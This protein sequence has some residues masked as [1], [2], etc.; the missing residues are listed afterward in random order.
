MT[1]IL[2]V[3]SGKG[4][5]GKSVFTANL[6]CKLASLGKTVILIDLD[7]GGAN[8]HTFL[9]LKNRFAGLGNLIHKQEDRFEALLMKTE[10]DRLYFIPGDRLL[11]GTA[12]LNFFIKQ[13]IIRS[14]QKLIAD[15]IILDLG[16]GSSYNTIDFFL[17]SPTG[18][19]LTTPETPSI[20]NAYG[21]LK[22]VVFRLLAR[23]FPR[24][25][26]ERR[27]VH[28]F[29]TQRIE[30]SEL[31]LQTLLSRLGQVS[32]DSGDKATQ[33]LSSLYP[34]VVLNMGKTESDLR[35]GTK[36]RSIVKSNLRIEIEY[37][38][39]LQQDEA[40]TRSIITRKPSVLLEPQSKFSRSLDQTARRLLKLP[41]TPV[42]SLYEDNQDLDELSS[43]LAQTVGQG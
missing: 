8:L 41:D 29:M 34:R 37:I 20:L 35:L 18:I 21:F 25:S 40:I 30:G 19:L 23:S 13:K 32:R 28:S 11:P 12:N 15:Y 5:V 43:A 14:I 6:G 22:S 38:G 31:S 24:N 26:D 39:F 10:V 42:L 17:S 2:P 4:G 7:L 1:V 9:G 33:Q 36:L 16:A 3:A 27:I